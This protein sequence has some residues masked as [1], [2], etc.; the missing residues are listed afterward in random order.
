MPEPL[1]SIYLK[2]DFNAAKQDD[3]WQLIPT[4]WVL[5]A[6]KRWQA[7]QAKLGPLS[8]LGVD[9]AMEGKDWTVLAPR[10][11][12]TI[13]KLIKRRGKETPDGQSV[14]ALI[15]NAGGNNAPTMID[16]IGIGKSAVDTARMSGLKTVQPIVV[17][18]STKYVDPKIPAI[19]F[20][21]LRA[22]IMWHLRTL[23]DP[24]GGK[25]ET[26]LALPPDNELI[27]DLTAPRYEMR[28][29]GIAV[30]N[31]DDIRKRIGRSTDSGDAVA[32][33]CWIVQRTSISL[34]GERIV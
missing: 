32:L 34:N 15:L 17:S 14:L 7:R 9:V 8:Q 5:F 10:F 23:L 11:G 30:E 20:T 25:E 24:E 21:N 29:S 26:R 13:A 22:A 1:R 31:K 16:A 12:V 28:V 33:S 19:R 2:G 4:A 3:R 6:Q 27:A 18:E